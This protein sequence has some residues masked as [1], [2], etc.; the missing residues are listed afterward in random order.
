MSQL[1]QAVKGTKPC[2]YKY[3]VKLS[4]NNWIDL[5]SFKTLKKA[6]RVFAIYKWG[7]YC[8]HSFGQA[9]QFSG[10]GLWLT[11]RDRKWDVN[12]LEHDGTFTFEGAPLMPAHMFF[13][14]GDE[15]KEW[16]GEETVSDLFVDLL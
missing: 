14:T 4:R 13:K 15:L 16:L 3:A 8:G 11:Y 5:S 10:W 6:K 7:T 9:T 12:K 1:Y 2:I